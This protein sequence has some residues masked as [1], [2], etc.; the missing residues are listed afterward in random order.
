[1]LAVPCHLACKRSRY[2]NR[3][4]KYSNKAVSKPGYIY[5]ANLPSLTMPLNDIK[6]SSS[7]WQNKNAAEFRHEPC[8][9][10]GD[11]ANHLEYNLFK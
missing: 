11:L 1:M 6:K 2:S 4:V 9:E 8:N 5:S 3:T 7:I 10:T